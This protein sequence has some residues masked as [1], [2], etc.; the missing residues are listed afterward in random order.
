MAK[1]ASIVTPGLRVCDVG[2]DHALIDIALVSEGKCPHAL[3][4]DINEGPLKGAGSNVSGEGLSSKITLRLSD[5]L[6]RYIKGE[7]DSLIISGMGGPL[8]Q[9]ILGRYLDTICDKNGQKLFDNTCDFKEMILSPQSEIE[10]FRDFLSSAG[11]RIDDE[12][13][14]FDEG[15]YYTIIKAVPD[16]SIHH[17]TEAERMF[18]P[19]L[20]TRPDPVFTDYLRFRLKADEAV[21]CKLKSEKHTDAIEDRIFDISARC[22]IISGLLDRGGSIFGS[23]DGDHK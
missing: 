14:V 2:C 19:V 8:M 1:I 4:M 21:L 22:D 12:S 3:A 7:A 20:T 17:L 6:D 11:L 5:G 9:D 13:M 10:E 18:G 15:K 16:R 23:L